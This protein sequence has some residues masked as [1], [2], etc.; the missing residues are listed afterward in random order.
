MWR[1]VNG[2]PPDGIQDDGTLADETRRVVGLLAQVSGRL[3][4]HG[5]T[6]AQPFADALHA[7]LKTGSTLP[8]Q[9]A[10]HAFA[11]LGPEWRRMVI[12]TMDT[13][14]KRGFAPP[15]FIDDND[16]P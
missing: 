3:L 15:T 14:L 10:A 6:D 12:D 1:D 5:V 4:A 8:L 2:R 9:R 16:G 7:T 11:T 13:A